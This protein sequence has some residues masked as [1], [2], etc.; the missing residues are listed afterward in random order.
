MA[1]T[2]LASTANRAKVPYSDTGIDGMITDVENAPTPSV[3]TVPVLS[4]TL[5]E[6]RFNRMLTLLFALKP[7]PPT[8]SESPGKTLVTKNGGM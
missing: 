4:V 1:V 5:P 7:E 8:A 6:V 3:V 2:L